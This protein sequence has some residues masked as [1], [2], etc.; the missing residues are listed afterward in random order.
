MGATA[1]LQDAEDLA[2]RLLRVDG[3][4]VD[5]AVLREYEVAMIERAKTVVSMATGMTARIHA[6]HSRG[7]LS[8]IEW[9]MWTVG[10]VVSAVSTFK[11][12][13]AA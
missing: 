13:V 3:P 11:S 10:W 6:V 1:A 2:L 7:A 8:A 5:P 12:R 9:I 4:L